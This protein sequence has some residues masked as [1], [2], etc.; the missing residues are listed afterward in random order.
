MPHSNLVFFHSSFS[1]L[2]CPSFNV[3]YLEE[4]DLYY[5]ISKMG[6]KSNV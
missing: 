1:Y 6:Y 2:T 4:R 3:P 5:D